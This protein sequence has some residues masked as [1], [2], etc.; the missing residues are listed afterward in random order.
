VKTA[1]NGVRKLNLLCQN[2][3]KLDIK[4][5]PHVIDAGLEVSMLLSY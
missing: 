1:L 2:G 5:N 4:K 3:L